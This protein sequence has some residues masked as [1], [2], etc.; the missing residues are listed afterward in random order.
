M[1][2]PKQKQTHKNTYATGALMVLETQRS[3]PHPATKGKR[4]WKGEGKVGSIRSSPPPLRVSKMGLSLPRGCLFVSPRQRLKR[5]RVKAAKVGEAGWRGW[6][7]EA[8][9]PQDRTTCVVSLFF[10]FFLL[11]D[12][13]GVQSSAGRGA[14]APR[15]GRRLESEKRGKWSWHVCPAT[16]CTS[17]PEQPKEA[18][19]PTITSTNSLWHGC[20]LLIFTAVT[21]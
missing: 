20:I 17:N 7:G 13:A 4:G 6:R 1:H 18:T 9:L 8:S 12:Y 16:Y 19:P 21:P 15:G 5:E 11:G 14:G 2:T 10:F 3:M